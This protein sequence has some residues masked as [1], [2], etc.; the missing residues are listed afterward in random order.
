MPSVLLGDRTEPR[1][2]L[3]PILAVRQLFLVPQRR[4]Y[5]SHE[6]FGLVGCFC[7]G[8]VHTWGIFQHLL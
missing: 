3:P 8:S 2:N 5:L 4:K 6:L 1:R 7:H